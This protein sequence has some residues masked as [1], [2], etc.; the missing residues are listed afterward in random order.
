MQGVFAAARD[1]T[2]LKAAQDRRDFTN[3]L[4]ELFAMK[5]S[6]QEYLDSAV[7][8]IR[9]WSGCEAVGIRITDENREIPFA[10]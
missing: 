9:A 2:E 8:V 4:L 6:S 7:E 3:S 1:V 5:S 10:S